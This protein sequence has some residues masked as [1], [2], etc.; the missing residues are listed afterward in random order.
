MTFLND[1]LVP[2]ASSE[3]TTPTADAISRAEFLVLEEEKPSRRKR[4]ISPKKYTGVS[5]FPPSKKPRLAVDPGILVGIVNEVLGQ[6]EVT[7]IND[8]TQKQWCQITSNYN[9]LNKVG[10]VAKEDLQNFYE[11]FMQGKLSAL[12]VCDTRSDAT[13]ARENESTYHELDFDMTDTQETVEETADAGL[14]GQ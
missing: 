11:V 3:P 5:N 7:N 8:I 12:K 9:E 2:E 1:D 14:H 10:R 4:N 13:P 6:D